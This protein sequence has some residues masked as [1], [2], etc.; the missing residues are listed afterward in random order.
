MSNIFKTPSRIIVTCSKRHTTYLEQEIIELGYTPVRTFVTGVELLGTVNDCIVLNLN[1]RCCSQVLYSLK[2]FPANGPDQV[3]DNL[4]QYPW[5]ELLKPDGYFSITSNADHFTI[6]NELFVN[7]KVKGCHCRSH[8]QGNHHAGQIPDRQKMARFFI[9]YWKEEQ[10]EIFSDTSGE[11]LAKHGYRKIPGKAPMMESLAAATVL[12]TKWDRTSP[13]VN[14]M[15][16][17]STVAIE[18][19]FN[20]NQ[21][22]TRIIQK[23]LFVHA[24]ITGYDANFY[25]EQVEKLNMSRLKKLVT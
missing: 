14:P 1:L 9:L 2:E 20:R 17:S 15:C 21:S 19:V 22:Q 3:Y 5:E 18:A 16:G 11:T 13:F 6:N 10:A 12:A 7:V 25:N 4:I 8:A 23:A 24:R